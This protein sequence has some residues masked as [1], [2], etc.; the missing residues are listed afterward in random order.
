[1]GFAH[2]LKYVEIGQQEAICVAQQAR[3]ENPT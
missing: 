3:Y 2:I 1:M